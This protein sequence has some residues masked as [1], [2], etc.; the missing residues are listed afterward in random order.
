[1]P[2]VC[3]NMIE[4]KRKEKKRKEKKRKEKKRKEKKRKEKNRLDYAF[5]HQF[6]EEPSIV[7]GSPGSRW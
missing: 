4:R 1:M 5:R 7:L 6:N 3:L 2:L